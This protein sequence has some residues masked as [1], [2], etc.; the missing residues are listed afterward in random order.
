[1]EILYVLGGLV[2]IV[3][4]WYIATRNTIARA[5]VKIDELNPHRLAL[6]KRYDML[7]K[8]LTLQKASKA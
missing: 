7:T 5:E 1:M 2:L 3:L 4:I 6:T 8:L